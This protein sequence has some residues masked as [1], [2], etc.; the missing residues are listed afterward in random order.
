[1]SLTEIIE[2]LKSHD[3]FYILTHQYPDGDTLGSAFALCRA[4]QLQGKR[5]RVLCPDVI[6]PKYEYLKRGIKP[7]TDFEPKYIISVDVADANL[8]G[9]LKETYGGIVDMCIDHHSS[10]TGYAKCSYVDGTKAAAAE[11]IYEVIKLLGVDFDVDIASCIY[12][13]IS[14]DTG[15]FRYTNA[16]PQS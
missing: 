6:A 10:N 5:A 2:N 7:Q 12:T 14:T 15:C 16:T 9:R 1:M 3:D 4:L 13:A 11:I 8:L